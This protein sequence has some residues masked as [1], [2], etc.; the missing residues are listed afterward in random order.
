MEMENIIGCQS[1][2]KCTVLEM[3]SI[4]ETINRLDEAKDRISNPEDGG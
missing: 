3:K 1:E 4:L 2:M